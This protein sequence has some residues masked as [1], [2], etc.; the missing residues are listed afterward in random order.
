MTCSSAL[1]LRSALAA[2]GIEALIAHLAVTGGHVLLNTDDDFRAA[3]SHVS[4]QRWRTRSP[5]ALS[6]LGLAAMRAVSIASPCLAGR[7][8]R[9]GWLLCGTGCGGLLR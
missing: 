1:T 2:G 8:G 3:S 5:A 4:L 9:Q 7:F 6:T